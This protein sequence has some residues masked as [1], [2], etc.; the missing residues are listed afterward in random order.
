MAQMV[1]SPCVLRSSE[2]MV[3]K[4]ETEDAFVSDDVLVDLVLTTMRNLQNNSKLIV[5][6][7]C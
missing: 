3:I 1:Y 5:I 2:F 7:L 4:Q 6:I